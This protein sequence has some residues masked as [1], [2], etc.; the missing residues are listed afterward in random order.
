MG[1]E[2]LSPEIIQ[3]K[4]SE[5]KDVFKVGPTTGLPEGQVG[6]VLEKPGFVAGIRRAWGRFTEGHKPPE[7]S[8][9]KGF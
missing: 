2:G 8:W 9:G 1:E 7:N 3:G 4:S 6:P 5:R